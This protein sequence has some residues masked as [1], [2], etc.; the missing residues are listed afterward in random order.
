MIERGDFVP[1]VRLKALQ[2]GR[3]A[4]IDREGAGTNQVACFKDRQPG[5]EITGR[6][7]DQVG[8]V[9]NLLSILHDFAAES[10]LVLK[11]VDMLDADFSGHRN[12]EQPVASFAAR[13]G[14]IAALREFDFGLFDHRRYHH[15]II[16]YGRDR[17]P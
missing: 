16:F 5:I 15:A 13:D 2:P 9:Q 4:R 14:R 17:R 7:V 3:S 11:Q 10:G 12:G 6:V 1:G 8:D